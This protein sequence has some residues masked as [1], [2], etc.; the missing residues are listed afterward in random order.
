LQAK[1]VAW[2][3]DA[4]VLEHVNRHLT[5]LGS[6]IPATKVDSVRD[7]VQA[8]VSDSAW[9]SVWD[10]V[11]DSV[12]AS[13]RDSAWASVWD[14]VRDSAWAS[15]WDSVECAMVRE[16]DDN[17]WLPLAELATHGVYLYGVTDDGTA[18]VARVKE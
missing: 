3:D 8:S 18:Y 13:V 7:S 6:S 4:T 15:V 10:S 11:S 1:P 12:Q 9:A 16:D 5:L 17:P 14:S 2:L